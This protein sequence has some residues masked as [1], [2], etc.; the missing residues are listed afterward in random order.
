[1]HTTLGMRHFPDDK[2]EP[3]SVRPATKPIVD[4]A[5]IDVAAN[6]GPAD[7]PLDA[8][9]HRSSGDLGRAQEIASFGMGDP[10]L[11]EER[12]S[13]VIASSMRAWPNCVRS[14]LSSKS[15]LF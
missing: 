15:R 7:R 10:A 8:S 4:G 2:R 11:P 1:M 12:S 14:I 13:I 5:E 6:S 3:N 9:A